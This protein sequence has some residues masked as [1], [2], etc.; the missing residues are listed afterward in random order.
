MPL[1]RTRSPCLPTPRSTENVI[2][3]ER[4][5]ADRARRL[6]EEAQ[7]ALFTPPPRKH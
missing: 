1:S 3:R 4:D 5:E 6:A 2:T 7:A